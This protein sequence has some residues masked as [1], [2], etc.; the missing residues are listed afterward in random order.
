MK[1]LKTTITGISATLFTLLGILAALPYTLGDIANI[2]PSKHKE[3]IFIVS[4]S[5]AAALKVWNSI[6]Q[7]DA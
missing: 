6:V 4:A 2:L 3:T 7:K 5:A 1:N